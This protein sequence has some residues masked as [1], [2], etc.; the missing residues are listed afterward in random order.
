MR[1]LLGDRE[2]KL[3]MKSTWRK[4]PRSWFV[5]RS[6]TDATQ[7]WCHATLLDI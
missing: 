6:G 7:R 3:T 5:R 1:D 2:P 4:P